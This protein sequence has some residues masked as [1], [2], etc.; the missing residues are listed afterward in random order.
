MITAFF[1]F[2]TVAF[3]VAI[4]AS[5]AESVTTARAFV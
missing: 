4:A 5:V 1:A 3:F 2:V